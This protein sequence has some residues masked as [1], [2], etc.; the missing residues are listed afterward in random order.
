M[1]FFARLFF[2]LFLCGNL[3]SQQVSINTPYSREDQIFIFFAYNQLRYTRGFYQFGI[4]YTVNF[5][6]MFD[7]PF[8]DSVFAIAFG[9]SYGFSEYNTSARFYR[10]DDGSTT[11][12]KLGKSS[13]EHSFFQFNQLSVPLEFRYRTSSYGD[14]A[15]WRL[16]LGVVYSYNVSEEIY[17]KDAKFDYIQK[18]L[19]VFQ[20]HHTALTLTAGYHLVN[21]RVVYG[22]NDVFHP[23]DEGVGADF[24]GKSVKIGLILYIF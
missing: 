16:A 14:M 7:L 19:S 23:S 12:K 5:G 17:F 11:V 9:G 21:L 3:F 10:R 15:F 6:Y 18:D 1:R 2:A 4:P 13:Y 8:N 20:K 24:S 22:L